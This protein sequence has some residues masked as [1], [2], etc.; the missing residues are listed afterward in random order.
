M[1]EFDSPGQLVLGLITGVAFGFLLQKGRVAKYQT[2]LAQL[3]LKDWTVFKFM[4]SAIVTGAVGVYFLVDHG[5]ARLD[6]WPLQ[7]AAMALGAILFGSGLAVLGYCPGTGMAGAGE[8][9][10]DA[11]VGV[12]GMITGAA[13]LVV[14]FN[15]LEPLALALGDWGKVTI[16]ELLGSSPW[17][18]IAAM[19]AGA[20]LMLWLIAGS[21]PS[22]RRAGAAKAA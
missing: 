12:L 5:H 2:I 6:I 13:I 14:G 10:R 20:G 18:V 16:P 21:E 4:V 9:S 22:K 1:F 19:A 17:L 11:M 8:G 3:L 15:A 7:P